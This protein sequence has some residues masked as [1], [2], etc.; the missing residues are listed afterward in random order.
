MGCDMSHAVEGDRLKAKVTRVG[1]QL[2]LARV[3]Y[4]ED[5]VEDGMLAV[6]QGISKDLPRGMITIYGNHPVFRKILKHF[7]D[8]HSPHVADEV[9]QIVED[10]YC[11]VAISKLAHSE[12]M[13]SI[14][15]KQVISDMRSPHSLTIALLGLM[16]EDN[17]IRQRLSKRLGRSKA[18]DQT[19][20]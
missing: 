5:S 10:V 6:Y 8:Q 20:A 19:A 16:A 1:G 14:V 13:R 9:R 7:Q 11:G 18:Q 2:P 12:E 3:C 17:L 15:D 4:D